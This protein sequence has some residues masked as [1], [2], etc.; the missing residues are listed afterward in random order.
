MLTAASRGARGSEGGGGRRWAQPQ[1]PP[2]ASSGNRCLTTGW[3]AACASSSRRTGSVTG[4]SCSSCGSV[5]ASRATL[6]NASTR[7]SSASFDSVSVGST[8]SASSTMSG[9]YVVG[10]CTP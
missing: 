3:R 2:S 7:R 1:A 10:G 6:R 9:K 5:F 4:A 8:M